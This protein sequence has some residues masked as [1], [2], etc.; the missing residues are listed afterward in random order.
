MVRGNVDLN[1][2]NFDTPKHH[3]S[4]VG[5]CDCRER[6]DS[7]SSLE[8]PS[9]PL[10]HRYQRVR[11][12]RPLHTQHLIGHYLRNLAALAVLTKGLKHSAIARLCE[13]GLL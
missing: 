7:G 4:T 12:P 11:L 2:I 8:G 3:Q 6:R 9:L 5:R 10:L 13:C 1:V